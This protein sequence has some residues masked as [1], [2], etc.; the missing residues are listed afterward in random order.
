M[1]TNQKFPGNRSP[2]PILV[3]LVIIGVVCAAIQW[4]FSTDETEKKPENAP[5]DTG[6][7]NNG[8]ST[9]VSAVSAPIQPISVPAEPEISAPAFASF[10]VPITRNVAQT[11]TPLPLE[12]KRKQIKPEDLAIALQRGARA[13]SL[14]E[15]V[16]AL[17]RL[18][19][20][21]SAAYAAL[22]TSGRFSAWL[23]FTPDGT[24]TWTDR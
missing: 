1:N 22:S 18:G 9:L 19:F 16:E 23:R 20:R 10:F 14:T 8:K 15:A 12:R 6:T 13:F 24:I 11:T 5:T 21:K 7:E 17:V 3:V 2:V 4:I